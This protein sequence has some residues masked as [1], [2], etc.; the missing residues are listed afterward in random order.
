MCVYACLKRDI[1]IGTWLR[2]PRNSGIQNDVRSLFQI[3]LIYFHQIVTN[4]CWHNI[5]Q[6]AWNSSEL[7]KS[8]QVNLVRTLNWIVSILSL[9]NLVTMCVGSVSSHSLTAVFLSLTFVLKV[10]PKMKYCLLPL[11]RPICW[12]CCNPKHFIA[13]FKTIF[14]YMPEVKLQTYYGMAS[15]RPSARP[16]VRHMSAQY[17]KMFLSNSHDTW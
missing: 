3:M 8:G 9:L 1:I 14:Y 6:I 11:Q 17:L 2:T 15:V 7:S 10:R 16:A 13:L 12:H 4:V 5:G